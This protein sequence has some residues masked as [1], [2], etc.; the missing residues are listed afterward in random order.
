MGVEPT[1]SNGE[2]FQVSD[3]FVSQPFFVEVEPFYLTAILF[4]RVA[5]AHLPLP[6]GAL[7]RWMLVAL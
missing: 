2:R 3:T 6:A 1:F 7:V 4:Y 5:D